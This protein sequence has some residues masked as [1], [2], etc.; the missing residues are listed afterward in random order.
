MFRDS[1]LDFIVKEV[2]RWPGETWSSF[3]DRM[4]LPVA[5][6]P[7]KLELV[8]LMLSGPVP[9]PPCPLSNFNVLKSLSGFFSKKK[10]F[11][12]Q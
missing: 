11:A 7:E 1:I 5:S 8:L 2:R 3:G 10:L 9:V 6:D 4:P 12:E